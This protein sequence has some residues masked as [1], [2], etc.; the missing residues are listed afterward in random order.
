[1]AIAAIS[2]DLA[3]AD[4]FSRII[5][6]ASIVVIAPVISWMLRRQITSF[7]SSANR[8]HEK[9]KRFHDRMSFRTI[10]K[11]FIEKSPDLFSGLRL[12]AGHH[13]S[14]SRPLRLA[15]IVRSPG[16][17][18]TAGLQECAFSPMHAGKNHVKDC[19]KHTCCQQQKEQGKQINCR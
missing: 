18:S 15:K 9:F 8:T 10:S 11:P 12:L 4:G 16:F 19:A 17:S 2:N 3:S 14:S 6:V 13:G 1:V 7:A 5:R